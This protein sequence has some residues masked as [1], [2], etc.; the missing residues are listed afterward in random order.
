MRPIRS[1]SAGALLLA[2]ALSAPPTWAVG[3]SPQNATAKQNKDA[4]KSFQQAQRLY[5]DKKYADALKEFRASYDIVASPNTR[6]MIARVL[7]DSGKL[8]DAY[9]ELESTITDATKAGD[10]YSQAASAAHEDLEALKARVGF[11][12]VEVQPS[13]SGATVTIGS[14]AF[15]ADAADKPV[16]VEPGKVTVVVTGSGGTEVKKDVDVAAGAT[17]TVSFDLTGK[18]VPTSKSEEPPS[19]QKPTETKVELGPNTKLRTWAYVAGGVG[20]AGLITFGVF[21]ILNNSKYHQLQ[22]DCPG[23]NCPAGRSNDIDS[24]RTY[25]T[26]ANIGLVVGIVGVAAGTT[27]FILSSRKTEAQPGTETALVVAPGSVGVRGR[28]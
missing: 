15:D 20:A 28:F 17:E 3:V 6:L 27:L 18:A 1:T 10:K 5:Q 9:A 7:R 13:G 24:G 22:D 21:G 16:V 12:K 11:V 2:V 23:G 26:I 19:E 14:H 8:A 25:Q 4:S